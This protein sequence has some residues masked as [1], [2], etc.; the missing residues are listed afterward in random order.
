MIINDTLKAAELFASH[1][2]PL[3]GYVVNRVLDRELLTCC[4]A[5]LQ[6]P[7]P[8]TSTRNDPG[9]MGARCLAP[10]ESGGGASPKS[11]TDR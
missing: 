9:T 11:A 5:G 4:D 2:V 3:S 6:L 8:N 7:V 1:R 10:V